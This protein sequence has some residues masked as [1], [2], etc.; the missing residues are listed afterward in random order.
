MTDF[1]GSQRTIEKEK[2]QIFFSNSASNISLDI[3]P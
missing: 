2:Q 1:F 3:L